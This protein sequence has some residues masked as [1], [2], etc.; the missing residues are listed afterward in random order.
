MGLFASG[1]SWRTVLWGVGLFLW[2]NGNM[3]SPH[4]ALRS[5]FN[6]N[7]CFLSFYLLVTFPTWKHLKK[8]SLDYHL[9]AGISCSPA[10][11]EY[12]YMYGNNMQSC[13]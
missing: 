9:S 1:M 3:L 5:L 6:V 8:D 13:T 7:V 12:V 2:R 10:T 4:L 11:V